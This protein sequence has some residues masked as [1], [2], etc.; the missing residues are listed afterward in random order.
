M[1]NRKRKLDD[2]GPAQ[3]PWHRS[4]VQCEPPTAPTASATPVA[5]M[6]PDWGVFQQ[7]EQQGKMLLQIMCALDRLEQALSFQRF[8]L[9]DLKKEVSDLQ[10]HAING[11]LQNDPHYMYT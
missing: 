1:F 6:V 4:Q 11:A 3:A 2:A 5:Q 7:L 10:T 9:E 8:A